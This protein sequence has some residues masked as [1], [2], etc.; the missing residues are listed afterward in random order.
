MFIFSPGLNFVGKMLPVEATQPSL[1][2]DD[3]DEPSPP[4]S[5]PPLETL[6]RKTR[7]DDE[8]IDH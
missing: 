1:F 4:R 8:Y 2:E 3:D 5:Y 6:K 7:D